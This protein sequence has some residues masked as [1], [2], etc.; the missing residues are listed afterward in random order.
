[1]TTDDSTRDDVPAGAHDAPPFAAALGD[2]WR[3]AA[4]GLPADAVEAA[5][6]DEAE[7]ARLQAE[8]HALEA[9][10]ER[11]DTQI[12]VAR[13]A[14]ANLA[15]AEAAH[16]AEAEALARAEARRAEADDALSRLDVAREALAGRGSVLYA[17][18]YTV[19]GALF[20][21]GDVIMSRE[22][23]AN[24]LKLRGAVEPWVFA[25]GLAMLA[26]LVKP[27]YDRLV[28]EPYWHGR[29]RPFVVT[30]LASAL[31]ALATLWVLGAFRSTAFIANAQ[32]QRRAAEL[33]RTSDPAALA[34][35]QEQI[36][37][38]QAELMASP[39]G[40]WAFVLSGVLFAVAGA[41]CLGI[42]LRHVRDVVHH[43]LPM[44]R[45]R[46]QARRTRADATAEVERLRASRAER[47]TTL[48]RQRRRLADD[49]ALDT[50]RARYATLADRRADLEAT[51][52]RLEAALRAHAYRRGH[53]LGRRQ[54][55]A[56]AA[57]PPVSGD[58]LASNGR[59]ETAAHADRPHRALRAL[60]RRRAG[61]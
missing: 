18:L 45:E 37:A 49:L 19:A 29:R 55:D 32:I 52:A 51:L 31:A 8:A 2:G 46:R 61:T 11:L 42:G 48:A 41:I 36:G 30:I 54:Q 16:E 1:M 3:D 15:A 53:A 17:A 39:L 28:E 50:L 25:L 58:G 33:A 34:Q 9:D 43:R 27:A 56:S 13:D 5:W 20:V 26:V 40:F 10:L 23:V 35:I 59:A 47:R 38:I 57:P 44:R 7:H 21:A 12:D 6:A 4:A 14:R 24:A 22:V 60:I